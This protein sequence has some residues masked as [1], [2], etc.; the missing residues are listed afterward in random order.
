MNDVIDNKC[1]V[2]NAPIKFD[3]KLGKFK[4]EYC[5]SEFTAE[6][7][8]NMNDEKHSTEK[9]AIEDE[10]LIYNCPDCGANIITDKETAATFCIYCGNTSI[11][12]N[13]LTG[14]FAP[15][16]IIP[17]K[18]TKEDA[19]NAFK[20]LKKGRPL[21]PKSFVS[22]KNIEKITGVYIP[23][24][25][26]DVVID[27]SLEAKGT[28]VKHWSSGDT[29]YIKTDYYEMIRKGNMKFNK[30]PV[31]GSTKFIDEIMNTIEPFDYS[32][33]IDYN[34]A[35]LS[36]FLAEKY[37]V[38]KEESYEIAKNRALTSGKEIMLSDMTGYTNKTV[39]SN[40]LEAKEDNT[41]YALLPVWMVNVKYNNKYYLFAMNGQTGEFI[42]DIPLDKKK[43]V[44]MG[45]VSFIVLFL[46]VILVSYIIYK[47]GNN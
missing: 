42:G 41:E 5:K 36:G 45:I 28:K 25:L 27:G 11:I 38:E 30:I 32:E 14:K 46:L 17:F 8:K 47:V 34:H 13:R 43:T 20:K 40:N 21:V 1:L 22:E 39:K 35:Y 24:W 3:P 18:K 7:L 23:F 37:N 9:E 12:K 26:F 44:I 4:C 19:I 2:C 15:S 31:D 16:K 10:Y 33:L 6:Q 29:R